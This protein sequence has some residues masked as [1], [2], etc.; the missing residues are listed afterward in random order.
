M[1]TATPDPSGVLVVDKPEGLTSHD[2]VARLRPVL[3]TGKVGHAGTLDP[4]AT[5]VLV[6]AYGR[7]TR[8]LPYLQSTRKQYTAT[9]RL[10]WGTT[11]DDRTG[12]P[13]AQPVAVTADERRVD[14]ALGSL[15][16]SIDQVP[17]TVS[18][19]KV[20]GRR[21]YALARAGEDVELAA[22]RVEVHGLRRTTPLQPAPD[23]GL[24]FD[25]AV[26]CSAGTYIRALARDAGRVLGCGAHLT[27]LRRTAVGPFTERDAAV[28]PHPGDAP[29]V[30]PLQRAASA[31]LP[32]LQ[33]TLDAARQVSLGQRIEAAADSP[34]GPVALL[35]PTGQL[36]AVA[37]A[38]G[39]VW[40][41]R[42]VFP[43]P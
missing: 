38:D 5:G 43:Q 9:V 1:T 35:G 34:G 2:V 16:G 25:I 18:A 27:A 6:L 10:G 26:T 42:V 17:S 21:A 40:C 15:V 29:A 11:T 37:V 36:L 31:V 4:M 3:A 41:Y 39:G 8:L 20:A 22:R 19:V 14:A 33:V 32:H 23:G 12:Q 24:D 7:G 28:L 30:M 13:L